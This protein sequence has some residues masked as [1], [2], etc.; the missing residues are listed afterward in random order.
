MYIS[1]FLVIAGFCVLFINRVVNHMKQNQ[2][3][4][5]EC[6]CLIHTGRG[7]FSHFAI[8]GWG[9][10]THAQSPLKPERADLKQVFKL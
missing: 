4:N 1:V 8:S 10:Q 5:S 2:Y 7:G 9:S 6:V 3:K